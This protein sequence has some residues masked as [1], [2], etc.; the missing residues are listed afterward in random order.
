MIGTLVG[1]GFADQGHDGA[2][3]DPGHGDGVADEVAEAVDSLRYTREQSGLVL[4]GP[5]G[6]VGAQESD[7]HLDTGEGN[8]QAVADGGEPV[9]AAEVAG[10]RSTGEFRCGL[11]GRGEA[12]PRAPERDG[13][14][15]A[16]SL[17]SR[18]SCQ[19]LRR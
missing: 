9:A 18:G 15:P 10:I 19:M 16:N 2:G 11:D 6:I 12:A 17:M 13:G 14:Q 4:A 1:G 8:Q 3:P 5:C 7:G